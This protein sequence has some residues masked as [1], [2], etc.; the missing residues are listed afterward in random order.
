[1]ISSIL[2]AA[3]ATVPATSSWSPTVGIIISICCVISVLIAP[4]VI[5][6][7]QVG[8]SFPGPLP[9]SIPAFVGAMCFGHLLGVAIVLGL[10]NIGTI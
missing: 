9:L 5:E 2:F 3:Q 8:P 7:P 1:M 6:Y 10:T 4:R